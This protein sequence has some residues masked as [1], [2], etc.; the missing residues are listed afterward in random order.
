[1][2]EPLTDLALRMVRDRATMRAS[3]VTPM[4][5]W[6]APSEPNPDESW[7][8]T[9]AGA[10]REV[11]PRTG[12]PMVFRVEKR[13]GTHNAFAMAVTIGRI[14]SN[15]V[16]ID[17]ASVS[18]FHAYL[19]RDA[20]TGLWLVTDAES[21]HGTFLGDM[22]L[23]PNVKTPLHDKA[24]LRVGDAELRFFF[25]QSFLTYLEVPDP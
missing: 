22:Q 15:D 16:Q 3:I 24:R 19:Q 21:N 25:P 6:L 17:D 18:R 11:R 1:M 7:E 14:D 8:H 9:D 5:V 13:A 2:P 20:K 23:K 10:G 12:N 4:L